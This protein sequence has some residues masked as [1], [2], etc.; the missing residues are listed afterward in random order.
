MDRQGAEAAGMDCFGTGDES[1]TI[2]GTFETIY[3]VLI[4][5]K[6]KGNERETILR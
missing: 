1:E 6:Q 3:G 4:F 5:Q 2:P